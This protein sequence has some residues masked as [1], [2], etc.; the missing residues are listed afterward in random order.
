MAAA[1]VDHRCVKA[2]DHAVAAGSNV[3]PAHWQTIFEGLMGRIA[4]RFARVE[5]RRRTRQLVLGLLADLP[6]KN[7]WTI[8][9]HTGDAHR[10]DC[11]TCSGARS[12]T[13][14]WSGTT[15]VNTCWNTSRTIKPYSWSTR[16]AT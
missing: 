11:S 13:P 12:G 10:T 2:E 14:I 7:C 3:V 1:T 6:R 8:A 15:C 4:A 9:E 5:P 16:P